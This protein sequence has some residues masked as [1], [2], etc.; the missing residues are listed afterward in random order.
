M[1]NGN[2]SFDVWADAR[3]GKEK[4]QNEDRHDPKYYQPLDLQNG[5]MT[6]RD[7]AVSDIQELEEVIVSGLK[8][9]KAEIDVSEYAMESE[10]F[11]VDDIRILNN[12]VEL[13]YVDMELEY[14]YFPIGDSEIVLS[15]LPSYL[16][17]EESGR[18]TFE[19]MNI[20]AAEALSLVSEDM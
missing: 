2:A 12:H 11:Y 16:M 15:V 17:D 18:R 7:E 19:Q 13:F 3:M 5:Q 4:L 14:Y 9:R 20:A 8:A 10:E 6:G 1:W